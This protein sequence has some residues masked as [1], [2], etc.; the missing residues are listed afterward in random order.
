MPRNEKPAIALSPRKAA[1]Y[2]W[3][4]GAHL[5]NVGWLPGIGE[6]NNS[7]SPPSVYSKAL[8]TPSSVRA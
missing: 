3:A 8:R 4:G 6:M 7:G 5:M 1:L 2:A